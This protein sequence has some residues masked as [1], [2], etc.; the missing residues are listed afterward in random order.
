MLIPSDSVNI[1]NATLTTDSRRVAKHFK[2]L[3]KNI[4][5]AYDDLDCSDEFRRLNFE[6]TM[7]EVVGPK[8][9]IRVERIVHMTKDGFMFLVMGFTG[10]EAARVKES[11]IFAFNAMAEQLQLVERAGFL[12]YWKQ[13]LDLEK[14]D[15]TSFTWASFGSRKMLDRRRELPGIRTERAHLETAMQQPLPGV[16]GP[17]GLADAPKLR[18]VPHSRRAS[19]DPKSKH[20]A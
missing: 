6:P 1:H 4:L 18:A 2:R 9:A 17:T 10:K 19:N 8:G 13:R 15:Q 16:E 20:S 3:H 12:S 5:R 11:Y 7:A 14:R